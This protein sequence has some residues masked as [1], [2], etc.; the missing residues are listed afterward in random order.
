M[1]AATFPLALAAA[2]VGSA[3]AQVPDRSP[4]PSFRSIE[5]QGG[6]MVTVRHGT[7]RR[8]T[9]LTANPNR[10]I[11]TDGDRL[12]IAPCSGR[13]P[14]G[15][16]I[17]VEIVT[18]E[19]SRVAVTDG[20]RIELRGDFPAQTALA[21]S[22]S[23][24]GLIDMR[25]LEAGQVTAAV[26]HGGRILARPGRGLTASVANGGNVTYWGDP[27]VTSSVRHGGVV[28]RGDPADLRRPL[29]RLDER[30]APPPVPASRAAPARPHRT[31]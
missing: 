28:Q 15:H 10:P 27:V 4:S 8:L 14:G 9:V 17:E 25:E 13:C 24:G 23:S 30:L 29:A 3:S 5:L 11:R 20:G 18:P 31:H 12:V 6:G 26:E 21:A 22:V 7:E 19:L 16:R 1:R 2:L